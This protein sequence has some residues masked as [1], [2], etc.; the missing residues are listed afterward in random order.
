[1]KGAWRWGGR[2]AGRAR[3]ASGWSHLFPLAPQAV[4]LCQVPLATL[5]GSLD[6]SPSPSSLSAGTRHPRPRPGFHRLLWVAVSVSTHP[7]RVTPWN[8][9]RQPRGAREICQVSRHVCCGRGWPGRSTRLAPAP[10]YQLTLSAPGSGAGYVF[11]AAS[12]RAV[13]MG[14]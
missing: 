4:P 3:G 5:P 13:T 14:R 11:V 12:A 10:V 1:M 6:S 8:C 7:P 9:G 2:V